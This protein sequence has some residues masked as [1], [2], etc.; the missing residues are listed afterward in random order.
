MDIETAVSNR[1]M[2]PNAKFILTRSNEIFFNVDVRFSFGCEENL[3]IF[4]FNINPL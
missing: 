3:S 4:G 1:T 2:I